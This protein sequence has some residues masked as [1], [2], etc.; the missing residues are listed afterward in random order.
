MGKIN[1]NAEGKVIMKNQDDVMLKNMNTDK[2]TWHASFDLAISDAYDQCAANPFK[3]MRFSTLA[4][5]DNELVRFHLKVIRDC[6][7][8]KILDWQRTISKFKG[9]A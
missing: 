5:D 1:V 3:V 7:N 9:A 8:V 6:D 2:T 4:F